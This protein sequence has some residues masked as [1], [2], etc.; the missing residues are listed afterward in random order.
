[1]AILIRDLGFTPPYTDYVAFLR[2]Q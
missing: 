1:L 2:G